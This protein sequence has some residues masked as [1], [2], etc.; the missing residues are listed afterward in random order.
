MSDVAALVALTI[1]FVFCVAYV[2]WCERIVSKDNATPGPPTA[3]A[4]DG[5]PSGGVES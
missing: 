4:P 5:S 2:R 3:A 1:F